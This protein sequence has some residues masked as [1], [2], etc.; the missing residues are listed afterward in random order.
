MRF[1]LNKNCRN[2]KSI[3]SELS[4]II[5]EPISSHP[6]TPK[7]E[8]VTIRSF[9]TGKALVDA[10]IA[11]VSVLIKKHNINPEQILFMLNSKINDSS[12]KDLWK[13]G[14][15]DVTDINR[16]GRLER[17]KIHYTSINSSK[18][19]ET[20]ILFIIDNHLV[21][22]DLINYAQISRAKNKVFIFSLK[23]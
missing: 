14:N 5:D 13:I 21:K 9:K 16:S 17:G 19:I 11:E 7:G 1:E 6:L 8:D 20:D 12:I 15:V 18:G 23:N 10:L 2:T 22:D 3:T 4:K